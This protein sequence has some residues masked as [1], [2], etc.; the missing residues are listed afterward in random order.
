[1]YNHYVAHATAEVAIAIKQGDARL[2]MVLSGAVGNTIKAIE[3]YLTKYHIVNFAY[4]ANDKVSVQPLQPDD[5]P[6]EHYRVAS[7]V[8]IGSRQI[9]FI[10]AFGDLDPFDDMED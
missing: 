7:R 10:E 4:N 6:P 9:G 2:G 3:D 1:L 5:K 8:M